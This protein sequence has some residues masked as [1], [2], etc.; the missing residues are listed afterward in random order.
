MY[1]NKESEMKTVIVQY[2]KLLADYKT[3]EVECEENAMALMNLQVQLSRQA[4]PWRI[5][6][7]IKWLIFVPLCC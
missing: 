4:P 2:N 3:K 1:E 6:H 7:I 5:I